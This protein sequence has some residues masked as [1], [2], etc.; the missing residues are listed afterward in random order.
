MYRDTILLVAVRQQEGQRRKPTPSINK[1][2]SRPGTQDP[3]RGAQSGLRRAGLLRSP[4]GPPTPI[5]RSHRRQGERG[6]GGGGVRG[7][8]TTE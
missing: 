5:I 7:G 2:A 8:Q 3:H 1:Q 4:A 6:G